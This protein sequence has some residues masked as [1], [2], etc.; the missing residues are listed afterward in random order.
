M[1][2]VYL[3]HIVLANLED[4]PP[5]NTWAVWWNRSILMFIQNGIV[6]GSYSDRNWHRHFPGVLYSNKPKIGHIRWHVGCK[7]SYL[8]PRF[9]QHLNSQLTR[10]VSTPNRHLIRICQC[11]QSAR[12]FSGFWWQVTQRKTWKYPSEKIS[13]LVVY[14]W[15][16]LVVCDI[17]GVP[18]TNSILRHE[19]IPGTQ[20]TN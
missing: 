18:L 9:S 7:R 5:I 1:H 10:W 13:Q 2:K 17:L 11:N 6:E 4:L 8:F 19:K 20:S 14:W 16:G 3:N 15:F 12:R